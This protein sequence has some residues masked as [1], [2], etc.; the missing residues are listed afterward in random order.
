M[1]R[2]TVIIG[3]DCASPQLVFY[4]WIEQLP[5]LK[6]LI[7]SGISA[8]LQSCDPPI[9]IPAWSV[10]FSG[11]DPG[12]LGI[13]GFRNRTNY[14]YDSLKIADSQ[15]IHQRRLWDYFTEAG[16][17]SI[18]IGVPQTF[19]VH[20]VRGIMISGLIASRLNAKSVYPAGV[21][22]Q[23]KQITPDYK[24]DIDNFRNED[25]K[26]LIDKIYRMTISRFKLARH[27]LDK[28][29][30]DIFILVEIGLDR[31]QHAFWQF[32]DKKSINFIADSPYRN[33]LLKYYQHLD[34]EIGTLLKRFDENT[35][36]VIVSDHGAKAFTGGFCINQWL[37][38]NGYLKLKWDPDGINKLS[39]DFID[40]ENTKVW[41]EGGYYAR[42]FFNIKGR[43]EN[44]I[45]EP[46][47]VAD[48]KDELKTRL[49]NVTD[50]NGKFLNNKILFPE[51]IYPECNGIPPDMMIY[52]DD[53][54]FRAIGSIGWDSIITDQND[55]GPDGANHDY[56][57]IFIYKGVG[58]PSKKEDRL[59]IYDVTPTVLNRMNLKVPA[60]LSG[61]ILF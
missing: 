32:T 8:P 47:Q 24:F 22:D 56:N 59:S 14:G 44:G 6:A 61:R 5:N 50:Y 31:L 1:K 27:F 46:H 4:Q 52:P 18:V 57:G 53:L 26:Q 2:K 11:T 15:W 51:E 10:M 55:S 9:T 12:S 54:N 48:L 7:S 17:N 49:D 19:P 45:I 25:K 34:F 39:I 13:Y 16:K 58:I 28:N 60:G 35:D 3:L 38:E 30:W 43:E 36:V 40:W 29:D 42:C 37:I 41:A 21:L 20:P 33:V 23:I